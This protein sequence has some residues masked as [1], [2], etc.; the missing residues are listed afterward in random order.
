MNDSELYAMLRQASKLY[1]QDNALNL[2]DPN[3]DPNNRPQR[4]RLMKESW[5]KAVDTVLDE[6]NLIGMP[7]QA[8]AIWLNKK[9][10]RAGGDA[11]YV[12]NSQIEL[13]LVAAE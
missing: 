12:S 13:P 1:H 3:L 10:G 4:N 2:Q 8:A 6:K 9:L 11:A 7:R 5:R